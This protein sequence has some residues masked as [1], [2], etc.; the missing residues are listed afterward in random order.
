MNTINGQL[1]YLD[2]DRSELLEKLYNEN[3]EQTNPLI[4]I[5]MDQATSKQKDEMK[6]SK[7]DSISALGKLFTGARKERRLK[8]KQLKK[9]LKQK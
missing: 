7:Y 1:E 2:C 6:V 9:K 4:P 5:D 8:A 3:M